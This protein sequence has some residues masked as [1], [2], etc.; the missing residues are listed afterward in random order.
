MGESWVS[1]LHLII[2]S[3]GLVIRV[4]RE[5]RTVVHEITVNNLLI[6]AGFCSRSKEVLV[7]IMYDVE[8]YLMVKG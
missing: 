8:A 1:V 6:H 3:Q 2:V 5:A 7:P 4:I